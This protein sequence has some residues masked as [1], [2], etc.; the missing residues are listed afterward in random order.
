V[1]GLNPENNVICPTARLRLAN[2]IYGFSMTLGYHGEFGSRFREN[3][4]EAELRKA[5]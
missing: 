3:A 2:P 4:V 1:H 5:F